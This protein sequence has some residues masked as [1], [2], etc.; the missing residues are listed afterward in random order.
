[1]WGELATDEERLIWTVL[2]QCSRSPE[3]GSLDP[4]EG[5]ARLLVGHGLLKVRKGGAV[6]ITAKGRK[7]LKRRASAAKGRGSGD[8]VL[9]FRRRGDRD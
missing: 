2:E 8:N 6:T 4:S 1:M 5:V 9:P 7:A 3:G